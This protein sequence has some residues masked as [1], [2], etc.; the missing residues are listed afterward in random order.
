M[1]EE[2]RASE[3]GKHLKTKACRKTR[4]YEMMDCHNRGAM[5]CR[6]RWPDTTWQEKNSIDQE[7]W[8]RNG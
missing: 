6:G 1:W 5:R 4:R 2:R 7:W 8:M 3:Q